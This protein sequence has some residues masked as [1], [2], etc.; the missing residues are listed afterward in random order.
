[1]KFICK[2][3]V[4]RIFR[5]YVITNIIIIKYT[6]NNLTYLITIYTYFAI[7]NRY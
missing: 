3:Y 6:F 5:Y 7:E 4:S 2:K 1:M